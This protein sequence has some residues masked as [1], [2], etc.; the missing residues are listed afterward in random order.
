MARIRSGPSVERSVRR[1]YKLA[2][3]PHER[4]ALRKMLRKGIRPSEMVGI[5]TGRVHPKLHKYVTSMNQRRPKSKRFA[6]HW[7][8]EEPSS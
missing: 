3:S 6:Y 1:G 4:V 7:R 2:L 8:E 5:T